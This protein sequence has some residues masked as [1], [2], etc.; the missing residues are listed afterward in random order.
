MKESQVG[1]LR[2]R[3]KLQLSETSSDK[4]DLKTSLEEIEKLRAGFITERAAWETDKATLAK[5]AED[6]EAALKPVTEE[7]SA[8]KQDIS[9]I[10]TTIF[11]KY[12]IAIQ[13]CSPPDLAY[14]Y[15]VLTCQ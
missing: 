15:A 10:T 4:A 2:K 5:R 12:N 1:N 8:I 6:A 7:L 14:V 13:F 11:G 9:K 3:L